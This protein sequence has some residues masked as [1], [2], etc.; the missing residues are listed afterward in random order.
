MKPHFD[1]LIVLPIGSISSTTSPD[2]VVDTLSSVQAYAPRNHKIILVDCSAPLHVGKR[3]QKVMPQIDVIR[4][5]ENFGHYG[6]VYMAE[7]LALLSANA[8][9]SYDSLLLLDLDALMIRGG[10]EH[11]IRMQFAQHPETGMIGTF[12][13]KAGTDWPARQL[14]AQSDFVGFFRDGKRGAFLR[15]LLSKAT[16]DDYT[17]GKH[18]LGGALFMNPRLVQKLDENGW[19][20]RPEL[21]RAKLK[22]DHIWSLLCAAAGMKL[23]TL[24]TGGAVIANRWRSLPE[25]PAKVL[26]SGAHIVHSVHRWGDMTETEIRALFAEARAAEVTTAEMPKISMVETPTVEVPQAVSV[27]G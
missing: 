19:L 7:S 18:L 16:A 17:A 21:A 10:I 6:G 5:Q 11:A 1:M 8:F 15:E 22:H 12:A 24:A 25:A 3:V 14:S 26:A 9:F 27:A 4:A 13:D 23:T 20:L 2:T